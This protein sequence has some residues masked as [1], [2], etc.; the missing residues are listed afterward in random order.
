MTL[1]QFKHTLRENVPP[2]TAAIPL[3]ALWWV[4]RNDWQR[5]HQLVQDLASREA[6]WV[7]AHLHRVEGDLSN[8][9]Y[10]Y[11]QADRPVASDPLDREWDDIASSL[12]AAAASSPHR[13]E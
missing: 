2:N 1:A 7:H 12:L 4:A 11:G 9:R 8:A 10:W 5:G 13:G 6:A 3:Q